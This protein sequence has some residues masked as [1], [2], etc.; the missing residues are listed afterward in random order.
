[1]IELLPG[2]D[3]Y[4]A[5]VDEIDRRAL[6]AAKGLKVVARYGVGVENVDLEA[7][8]EL[9]IVVTNTPA[10]NAVSVA[11]LTIGL[12]L[13]LV[14]KITQSVTETRSGNWPRIS[15][16]S[17]KG[18]VVGIAGLGSIGKQ[19]ARR[20]SGFD[21]KIMAYDLFPDQTF[22]AE[23]NVKIAS[24]EELVSQ[25]DILTI[26]LPLTEDTAGLINGEVLTR[27]KP[28]AY[29]V[30]TSRGG[31]VDEGAL[32][33]GLVS[34]HLAG[35][36]LDVLSSEPP[37]PNHPLLQAPNII[38]TPHTGAHTDGATNAMG[39]G[40]LKDCLAVLAGKQPKNRVV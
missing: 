14:R 36:A 12:I 25:A 15:G 24:F 7:A 23:N 21:C 5:G 28:G 35:A 39:W 10:A 34:G 33:E 3:G 11:E 31:L 30:N 38:I 20:L 16:L 2:C 29:I 18:K 32:L 6:E 9:G 37:S 17:L 27:M 19:V 1:L 40:A 26:H 13:N 8:Q 4:I 22:T